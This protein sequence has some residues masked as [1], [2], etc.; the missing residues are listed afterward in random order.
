MLSSFFLQLYLFFFFNF[1]RIQLKNFFFFSG[2]AMQY[3]GS[4]FPTWLLTQ[5]LSHVRLFCK[6]M[7][8][9]PTEGQART[10]V[11][12]HFLLQGIFLT[13]KL[14]PRLLHCQADS[15]PLVPFGKPLGS[16]TRDQ[17]HSPL[18]ESGSSVP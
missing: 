4:W 2:H 5:L 17:T 12:C 9:S 13:Q 14:N 18:P 3:T 11:G 8:C 7:D 16:P 10:R 6:P 1:S 15:L